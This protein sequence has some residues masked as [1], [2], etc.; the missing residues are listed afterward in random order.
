MGVVMFVTLVATW[1]GS[2]SCLIQTQYKAISYKNTI[3]HPVKP[4]LIL[5]VFISEYFPHIASTN[6]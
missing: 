6:S 4:V 2:T 5:L 1:F 3:Q